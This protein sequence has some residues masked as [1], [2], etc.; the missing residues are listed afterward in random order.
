MSE[1]TER[2]TPKR[3]REAREK[4]QFARSRLL[5]S[6]VVGLGGLLGTLAAAPQACARLR[7]WTVTLLLRQ[8]TAPMTALSEAGRGVLFLAGPGL[9]G[10]LL[11][12]VA[13]SV[14]LAGFRFDPGQV[15]PRFE[16]ID[17]AKGLRR[18]FGFERLLE[19]GKG[20]I[21]IGVL[22]VLV[23]IEARERLPELLRGLGC[24]GGAALARALS[25]LGPLAL[26]CAVVLVLLGAGDYL[27][28]R[29][30]HL[31]SLRMS[32]EEVK[33][34]LKESEGDPRYKARRRAL[35]RQLAGGGVARGVRAAT[36]VVVNPTHLAVALRYAPE[37]CDAP[38]LVAKGRDE[39]ALAL[40]R[41]AERFGIPVLRDVPLARGLIHYDVGEEIPEELYKAAAAVLHVALESR[42][43]G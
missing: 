7:A 17:P 24:D 15:L 10:A 36:A 31:R 1:K 33:Q 42:D 14:A 16:R 43:A 20:L 23:A 34:E 6:A 11:A 40:R 2:P 32:R 19:V 37:E 8:D 39:E 3:L 38:Y 30:R 9:A 29:W 5:S 22:G 18:L 21:A 25:G 26:R 28:A 4:G 41:E 27:L 35:H 12:S 13:L